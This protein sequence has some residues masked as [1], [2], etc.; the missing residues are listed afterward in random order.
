MSW[1]FLLDFRLYKP[2]LIKYTERV[3]YRQ[4]IPFSITSKSKLRSQKNFVVLC[5]QCASVFPF[6]LNHFMSKI[7]DFLSLLFIVCIGI[8]VVSFIER[9]CSLVVSISKPETWLVCLFL[10]WISVDFQFS[11]SHT[12]IV[13]GD[14]GLCAAECKFFPLPK[15]WFYSLVTSSFISQKAF[16]IEV[17]SKHSLVWLVIF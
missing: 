1:N 5:C 4:L 2:N 12:F 9:D 8:H 14:V 16:R 11:H 17:M 3:P 7:W 10:L 15:I 6:Y 13:F